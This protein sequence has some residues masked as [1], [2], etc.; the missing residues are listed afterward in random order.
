MA[1][2]SAA[3]ADPNNADS[4]RALGAS[5]AALQNYS[6]A[7][8]AFRH[9]VSLQPADWRCRG[10]LKRRHSAH[11]VEAAGGCRLFSRGGPP[12]ASGT[13]STSAAGHGAVKNSSLSPTAFSQ[14]ALNC[15]PLRIRCHRLQLSPRHSFASPLPRATAKL[16]TGATLSPEH[17]SAEQVA[18][19]DETI[20]FGMISRL[21]RSLGDTTISRRFWRPASIKDLAA[22]DLALKSSRQLIDAEPRNA[23]ARLKACQAI[24]R[25]RSIPAGYS[26]LFGPSCR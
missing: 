19:L 23:D 24:C 6:D 25:S 10:G 13:C 9:A 21:S 22:Y 17:K 14:L 11:L 15:L 18:P 1:L 7:E 5:S 4:W 12:G 26:S 20:S 2:K 8:N 16:E 3:A